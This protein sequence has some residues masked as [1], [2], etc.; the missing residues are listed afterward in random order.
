MNWLFLNPIKA[1]GWGGMENWMLKL[2]LG[3]RDRGDR[4]LM[5]ARPSS[6]WPDLCRK[7]GL[8]FE[9]FGFGVDLAP[10]ALIRLRHIAAAF[11]PD[12]VMAKGFR[13]VRYAKTTCPAAT[14][15]I[16][17][18]GADELKDEWLHQFTVK[19]CIDRIFV[20]SHDARRAFL[21]HPWLLPG[22]VAAIHNGVAIPDAAVRTTSRTQLCHELNLPPEAL[23]VGGAGRFSPEKRY[24]D[25]LRAFA[26][27]AHRT[28]ARLVLF[29]DGPERGALESLAL[30]L[31]LKGRV[32][33][34]GWRD[35]VR[36]WL[37]AFDIVVHPSAME[38]LPNAVLEAMAGGAAVIASDAGGTRE[39]FSVP[40]VGRLYRAGDVSALA[41]HLGELL[42][43]PAL[44][45][46]LGRNARS[47]V[48]A[49]FS[50]PVMVDAIRSVLESAHT[51]RRALRARPSQA[52]PAAPLSVQ[53]KDAV[54]LDLFDAMAAL[55]DAQCV[56]RSTRATVARLTRNKHDCYLK[57][58]HY[59][60]SL[61]W[62]YAWRAPEAL[63]NFR[64]AQRLD[65]A[66]VPVV[67]HLAAAWQPDVLSGTSILQTGVIDGAGS[68]S[69][70]LSDPAAFASRCH[71]G[72][73]AFAAWLG[74]L[75]SAGIAPHDLK[76]SNILIRG[77]EPV[78]PEFILL[79]LD[80]ARIRR[81]GGVSAHE[82]ERNLHQC[83]RSFQPLLT[84][85]TVLRFAACYRAARGLDATRF[86][87]MLAVVE[88][89]LHRR[90]TGFAELA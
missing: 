35:D 1:Q 22:K 16:K 27:T 8:A 14:I 6:P 72:T 41:A 62:R 52:A 47:H 67:P 10:W 3:L 56:S 75:H 57:R 42:G 15:A 23:L 54:P 76:I 63:T 33:F 25:A 49:H 64:I 65:L 50:I 13:Q 38:G 55:D 87:A 12:I 19:C 36:Q 20:D 61:A 68:L 58:F 74:H 77:P 39:I 21:R 31:G 59:P 73:P 46:T 86:R 44:C 2:C 81:W 4:C 53:R 45:A 18:P 7:N 69:R 24:A 84:R 51:A 11:Q 32:V 88:Q 90:G 48:T 66:G 82:A 40:D 9:P 28:T 43:D 71:R 70:L 5:V 29:G 89:R 37:P 85:R 34:T 78:A 26:E 79:D 17:M 60:A 30:T 80:N 83:F